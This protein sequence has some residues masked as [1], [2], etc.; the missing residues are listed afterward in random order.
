M[1]ANLRILVVAGL[2]AGGVL[3]MLGTIVS[4]ADVRAVCW[5]ID[6]VGLIIAT[7]ILALAFGRSGRL[8]V[9]AGFL[10]Y[11]IGESVMLGGTAMSLEASVPAFAAGTALWSAGLTLISV[12]R[13]FAV[14][15]RLAGMI[16]AVLFGIVSLSIF[17]GVSL[18]PLSRPLPSFAYPFLVITFIGWIIAILK[19]DV[20]NALG[21]SRSEAKPEAVAR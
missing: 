10:I 5:S 8:E 20:G 9:A 12:P 11:A 4:A 3:G 21:A 17:R 14:W 13:V 7:T 6:A 16:G 18:T 1:T 2:V 19:G 15:T